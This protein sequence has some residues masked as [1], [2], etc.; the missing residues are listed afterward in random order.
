MLSMLFFQKLICTF[1]VT[2]GLT[3]TPSDSGIQ[4]V[5]EFSQ[6]YPTF[7]NLEKGSIL[8]LDVDEVILRDQDAV[9]SP[10]GDS[11]KFQIFNEYYS[12]AKSKKEIE[13]VVRTLSLPLIL[14]QKQLVDSNLPEVIKKL[15]ERGVTVIGLTSCPTQSFGVVDNFI[16]WRHTQLNAFGIHL[17]DSLPG[18]GDFKLEEMSSQVPP[19]IFSQGVLF[20]EGF[21]KADVL[22][23]FLRKTNLKP[24]RIVFID[25]M[26]RNAHQME[27][28]L[29]QKDI[30]HMVF[31][32]NP[33]YHQQQ[34][35]I[36]ECLARFQY[37]YLFKHKKWLK[38]DEANALMK[39]N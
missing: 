27:I 2:L 23:A 35:E 32:F 15:Q 30:P 5:V 28:K 10:A 1:A 21:T 12:E 37:E 13:E 20:T 3:L 34:K 11:L 14:A 39:K 8:V 6:V 33:F 17:E 16:N 24:K 19:P 26:A 9:L 38:D 18:T 25:D 36:D 7:E 22:I 29:T 31:H 4:R